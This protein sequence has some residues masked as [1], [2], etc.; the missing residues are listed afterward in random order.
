[1]VIGKHSFYFPVINFGVKEVD[2]I[3]VLE[4]NGDNIDMADKLEP[5][6]P[7]LEM[8]TCSKTNN[9]IGLLQFIVLNKCSY[10]RRFLFHNF[11]VE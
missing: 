3:Q 2:H 6:I 7:R 10:G 8:N 5:F 1:V 9:P 4:G 11:D